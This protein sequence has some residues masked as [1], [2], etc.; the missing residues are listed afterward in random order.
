MGYHLYIH[1]NDG[2]DGKLIFSKINNSLFYLFPFTTFVE[3]YR[4]Y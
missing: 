3:T 1:K 4:C 2:S